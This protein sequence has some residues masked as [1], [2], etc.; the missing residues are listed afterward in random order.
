[1]VLTRHEVRTSS[2]IYL[3]LLRHTTW[4][5]QLSSDRKGRIEF[6]PGLQES[7]DLIAGPLARDFYIELESLTS[8]DR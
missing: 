2:L 4:P 5:F 7:H 6:S 1:V 3:E 8:R